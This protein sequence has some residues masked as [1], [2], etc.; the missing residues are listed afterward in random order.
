[1][2]KDLILTL[3]AGT[4]AVKAT[5]FDTL[6]NTVS[7]AVSPHAVALPRPGW[8]EQKIEDVLHAAK[9]GALS[10]LRGIDPARIAV[11]ALSGTMNGCLPIDENGLPL[12]PN[13]LHSDVRA[14]DEAA[15][16]AREITEDAYYRITGNRPDMHY[17]LPK[18]LWLRKHAPDIY[19]RA[20]YYIQTKDAMYQWLTG[21]VGFTDFSDATLTGALNIRTRAWDQDILRTL[22]LP[23]VF[24][25][26]LP[27]HDCTGRLA[28]AA[29]GALGLLPGTPVSIGGGD[30][31]CATH[32]AG[33]HGPGGAYINLGSS[34]WMGTLSKA[35]IDDPARRAFHYLDLD[36]QQ[37]T[38]CGTVQCAGAAMDWALETLLLAGKEV[39]PEAFLEI[40][41]LARSCP[42][43]AEGVFFLPTL[44]GERTPYWDP[45]A[46]GLLIGQSLY[47]GRRHIARAVY[48]GVAQALH[49]CGDA[50]K[51]A[52]LSYDGITLV[53]GG[54]QSGIY[55]Q[56][57][58][59][60]F[61]VLTRVH[62][63]PRQATSLGAA[64][65]AAVGVGL[66]A[67][68][69]DA[70]QM[71]RFQPK[72]VPDADR[73]KAYAKH[74]DVYRRL[75]ELTKDAMY[76]AAGFSSQP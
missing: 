9:E 59:D 76:L 27:A 2:P 20:R 18:V 48:E 56:L 13:I 55:P 31:A 25:T 71:A 45:D 42:P 15:L 29:G 74:F 50:F 41:Q 6:G 38:V 65:A 11:I 1:M 22:N 10:A 33:V 49:L 23:G 57:L 24:G 68:Y 51:S 36:G 3:D 72:K 70:A 58:A 35:P 7:A 62:M 52:G 63:S 16:I 43:G 21:R 5:V 17:T 54:T 67:S 28:A 34:A 40:E 32:G 26:P 64:M 53:G 44:M 19:R 60:A 46:R 47:H 8:A 14:A 39:T 75:Y 37:Y 12:C 66:R 69:A 4:T 30:G 61:G 73:V